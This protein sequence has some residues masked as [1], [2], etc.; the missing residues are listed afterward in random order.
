[1]LAELP[2]INARGGFAA[3]EAYAWH[4]DLI[5]RRG[6]DYDPIIAPRIRRGAE[7]SAA[8]YIVLLGQ[9]ADMQKRVAA[10]TADFDAVVMPTCAIVA[11][12]IAAV[13]DPDAFTRNNLL[14]LRNCTVGNFLDRCALSIPCHRA[15]ELPVGFMV[16][17]ETMGDRRTLAVGRAVES[18]LH[19]A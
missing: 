2:A 16:M 7:M 10:V 14:L 6:H 3:V 18:V 19:A 5:A 17:G 4:R 1:M 9:R 11:P 8:D 12:T 13:A 15:G